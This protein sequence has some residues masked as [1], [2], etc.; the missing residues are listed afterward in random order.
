MVFLPLRRAGLR[1]VGVFGLIVAMVAG[2]T[3]PSPSG[4]N[5]PH[6]QAN[7]RIHDFNR[8][9]DR[10]VVRPLSRVFGSGPA[11]PVAE[12]IGNLGDNLAL[13]GKIAN[14]VL[15]LRLHNA[16]HN[17]AR[18]A[19]NSTIGIG[20]LF[21]PASA[22]GLDERDTDFGETLHVWGVGEGAYM[23]LPFVGPTTERD[24]LGLVV[25]TVADPLGFV[26]AQPESWYARGV[27]IASRLGDRARFSDSV[28]SILYESADSYAQTRLLYLQNRR[29]E[30]GQEAS[31]DEFFDPYADIYGE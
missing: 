13:P 12:G 2:C 30:L 3:A 16:V 8:E 4:V 10:A 25:D 26:I 28:D 23:E 21:N 9:V 14:G 18:L 22:M 27:K 17:T 6:E 24:A 15:Q 5:D 7:R 20:G 29:F 1:S 31:D 19:I 11:G